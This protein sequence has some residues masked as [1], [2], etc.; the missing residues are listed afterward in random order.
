MKKLMFN[1]RFGLHDAVLNDTKTQTRRFISKTL[2]NNLS[3]AERRF[4]ENGNKEEY[5]ETLS[6]Q[7]PNFQKYEIGEIVAIAECYESCL[8]YYNE[9][10][11]T[12]Q[13][14]DERSNIK[15]ICDKIISL[16][17]NC[18]SASYHNKMFVRGDL[19]PHKIKITNI[20]IQRLLD[21]SDEDILKEG[22]FYDDINKEYYFFD[23]E[24]NVRISNKTAKDCYK[25]LI[26]KV[27]YDGCY[28]SNPWVI[29]YEF[30]LID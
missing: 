29:S 26:D 4:E 10:L 22:I 24:K 3:H 15:R 20:F 6:K 12:L 18:T 25:Q 21:I 2:T 5:L 14:D 9:K 28:D 19:M 30:E 23:K 1:N 7:V 16:T 17:N 11:E 13:N 8:K 27:S